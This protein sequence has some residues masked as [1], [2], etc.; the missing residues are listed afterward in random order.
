MGTA[1]RTRAD[2]PGGVFVLE[3]A[4]AN[5]PARLRIGVRDDQPGGVYT[6]LLIDER[7]SRPVGTLSVRIVAAA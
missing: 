4:S 6:G 7:T 5:E 1:G 3:A 2:Q